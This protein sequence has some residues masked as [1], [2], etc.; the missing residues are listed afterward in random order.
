MR[1]ALVGFF[2]PAYRWLTHYLARAGLVQFAYGFAGHI[3][4]A[5]ETNWGSGVAATH[6]IEG[7]SEDLTLDIDRF[8]YKAIIGSLSE[9]DDAT[10]LYRVAGSMQFAAHPVPIGHFLK[11]VLH[12]YTQTNVVCGQLYTHVFVTTSGGADF[13]SEVPIQ[14]YT[15]EIFRDVTSSQRYTGCLINELTFTMEP[16]GPVMCEATIV[17]RGGDVIAKTTPTFPTS[18]LKPFAFDTISLSVGGA[19]TA[20]I[21]SLNLSINNNLEGFGALNL[22]R[23][24]AKIRRNNHQMVNISGTIDFTNVTEYLNFI[25]QTEQQFT[26]SMTKASSF[27]LIFDIPRV[28]YTAYPT[29][30]PGRERILTSFEGKGFV[31]QGS[32]NAIKVTL[33]NQQSTYLT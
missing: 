10:G 33:T 21:E 4:L 6:Y 26:I 31:H 20:L 7:L 15:F 27:Q 18:P 5:R 8:S 13:S 29:G 32:L 22:S 3:G 16:N 23:Y 11:G 17:G 30:I 9:P 14:P 24:V 19:G 25:N 12:S 2:E 28:V 1:R